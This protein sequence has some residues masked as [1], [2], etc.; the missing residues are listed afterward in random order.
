MSHHEKTRALAIVCV[1]TIVAATAC[2]EPTDAGRPACLAPAP[3]TGTSAAENSR[4]IVTFRAGIDATAET[5]SLSVKYGFTPIHVYVTVLSGF[6]AELTTSVVAALRCERSIR[7]ISY[8]QPG[9]L[10]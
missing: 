3:L 4:Y 1:F 6:N 8:D 9:T 7:T 10:M 5:A 2:H